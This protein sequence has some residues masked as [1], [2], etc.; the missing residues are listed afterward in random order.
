MKD[1]IF[2]QPLESLGRLCTYTWNEHWLFQ[3]Q[4]VY[5]IEWPEG[6]E[7]PKMWIVSYTCWQRETPDEPFKQ[8]NQIPFDVPMSESILYR[9][10]E[11][12]RS[13]RMTQ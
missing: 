9:L 3:M 1:E 2:R 5:S 6:G 13:A 8:V 11:L 7:N 12:R 4:W 10:A